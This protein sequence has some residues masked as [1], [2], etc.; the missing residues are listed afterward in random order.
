MKPLKYT[1]RFVTP[2]FLG[3]AE[4]TGQWRT[5][6]FKAL[7]R[8]VLPVSVHDWGPVGLIVWCP[9]GFT[10]MGARDGE[11]SGWRGGGVMRAG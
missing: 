11:T 3:N 10:V 2:A 6:P 7:R 4:Q 1:V 8:R 5:P 9:H